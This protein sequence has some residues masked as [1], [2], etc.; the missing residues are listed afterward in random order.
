MP[1]IIDIGNITNPSQQVKQYSYFKGV[2]FS[3]DPTQVTDGRSP[4]ALNLVSDLSGFPEKRPGWRTLYTAEGAVNGLFYAVLGDNE[5]YLA[6]IGTKL[7]NFTGE[8]LTEIAGV[9]ADAKSVAFAHRNKLYLLDGAKYQVLDEE[10]NLTSVTDGEC[11]VPTTV[12][13]AKP[14]GSGT[15]FEAVNLLNPVRKNSFAGDGE[16][17]KYQLDAQD[18]DETAVTAVVEGEEKTETTDFTVDRAAGTVTFNTAPPVYSGGSGVDNVIITFSKTI[19]G[20]ADKINKCNIFARFGYN[21]DN[22]IFFAGNPDQPNVDWQ[23]GLDDPTYF[24][25]TGYTNIGSDS[26]KIMGYLKQYDNL[27]VIKESNEQDAE[28]FLRTAAM[29]SNDVVYFPIQQGV[30]GVGAIS[31]YAFGVLRDDP[32]FL[33]REGVYAI[34]S[35]TITQQRA[36]QN[37]SFFVDARLKTEQGL[38]NAVS[39]VWNDMYVLCVNGKCYI[40][41]SRQKS[42]IGESYGY[43]WYYWDNIP[44]RVFLEVNGELFFGTSDGK[45][46][47]FNTDINTMAKYNDDGEPIIARWS[48]KADDFGTFMLRKTMTKRGSGVMIR[49]FTRSSVN[50][51]GVTENGIEKAIRSGTMDIFTFA[52]IDF[53]RFTFNTSSSPQVVPFNR[54]LKKFITLQI[55]LENNTLDEGFGVYG[56][57]I[58]YVVGNYVK[59]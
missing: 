53:G 51:Y 8:E 49:P 13:G 58:Q 7:Y 29:D 57:I 18:I 36:V 31:K 55:I 23:S 54:K 47:K 33:S 37:R 14:N 19:E 11:F 41:N 2:D 39:V 15:A 56:V 59:K 10:L 5:Y 28:I 38:E 9:M 48:T 26:S 46:C 44:A 4:Y 35:T 21:N 25:D 34:T 50:V 45:I 43:E 27:I 16:T 17:K 3:T 32:L 22:R 20:Y 1:K 6:H 40:A 12:I 24:P 52:D 30:V 42:M